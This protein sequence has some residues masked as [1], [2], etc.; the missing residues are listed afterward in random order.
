MFDPH[1]L[2]TIYIGKDYKLRSFDQNIDHFSSGSFFRLKIE[3]GFLHL[4]CTYI[5]KNSLV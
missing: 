4:T 1:K 3:S 2:L 5:V